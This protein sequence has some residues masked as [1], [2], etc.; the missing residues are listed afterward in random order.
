MSRT[1]DTEKLM[2]NQSKRLNEILKDL[3]ISQADIVK[4]LKERGISIDSSRM[5]DFINGKRALTDSILSGLH[6]QYFINPQ[7]L[8]GQ[9]NDMYDIPA[10]ILNYAFSFAREISVIENPNR[11][12]EYQ[13]ENDSIDSIV[14]NETRNERYLHITMD[15]K[16]YNYLINYDLLEQASEKGIFEKEKIISCIKELYKKGEHEMEEYV[17]LPRNTMIEIVRDYISKRKCFQE[18]IDMEGYIDYPIEK[19]P[20]IK[21]SIK[22]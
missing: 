16:Y 18:L 12:I 8:S 15:K 14:Q 21:F 22:I 7:Y 20:K 17:L 9:S 11:K 13:N 3:N 6:M 19:N 2:K 4:S 5:S 10:T 1:K